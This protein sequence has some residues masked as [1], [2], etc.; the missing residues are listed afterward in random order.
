M[1]RKQ[2]ASR[3]VISKILRLKNTFIFFKMDVFGAAKGWGE[4]KK[5]AA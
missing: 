3:K 1:D 5:T 4:T 2:I